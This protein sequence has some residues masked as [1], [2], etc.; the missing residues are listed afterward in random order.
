[1]TTASAS[2]VARGS[3]RWRFPG[4]LGP[5]EVALG[6][7]LLIAFVHLLRKGEGTTFYYDEWNFVLYRPAWDLDT[8]LEPHNEH[9]SLVP[10]AVYKVL[11]EF[12]GLEHYG[13]YRAV[14]LVLHLAIAALLY[15]FVRE[16]AG[17]PL[18]LAS[19]ALILFLGAGYLGILWPFQIGFAASLA[20]GLGALLALERGNRA[21]DALA[22]VLVLVAL[23]SGSMGLPMAIGAL[24][25][26]VWSRPFVPARLWVALAPLLAY[27][28][29]YLA[30]GESALRRD[31]VTATP[32]YFADEVASAAGGLAGLGIEWGRVL[33]VVLALLVFRRLAAPLRIPP[34]AAMVLAV[35]VSFWVLTGLARAH[36]GEFDS[37]RYVYPGALFILLI[38][39]ELVR[40]YRPGRRAVALACALAV[41]AV[42]SG[43]GTMHDGAG[44][45]RGGAHTLRAQL[46]A[47]EIAGP[48]VPPDFIPEGGVPQI[49]AGPYF[50][51]TRDIGSSPALTEAELATQDPATRGAADG[52]LLRAHSM[53]LERGQAP[54]RDP[55]PHVARLSAGTLTAR[56]AC[57]TL[58]GE[59]VSADLHVIPRRALV[60]EP[61]GDAPVAVRVRRFADE[62][63]S[64][65]IGQAEPGETWLLRLPPGRSRRPWHVELAGPGDVRACAASAS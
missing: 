34:S 58:A 51:A 38:A 5:G 61:R 23:A 18:A 14:L 20:A 27:G 65:P 33:A 19:A 63:P 37:P 8:F 9:L 57:V 25:Y 48:A 31:N 7:L 52:I 62:F 56:G 53:S 22:G 36:L 4:R 10:V 46:A 55:R 41:G 32:R 6:V 30:Y 45:L 47:L 1:M 60:V 2:E 35:A 54:P 59:R 43:L 28:A 39:A 40:D 13:V 21:S 49:S 11:F 16:R 15:A 42:L 12:V 29:W 17:V 26:V 50:A 24:A 3:T 64:A 44:V